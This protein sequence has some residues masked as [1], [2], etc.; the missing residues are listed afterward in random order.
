VGAFQRAT[1]FLR[2]SPGDPTAYRDIAL[3]VVLVAAVFGFGASDTGKKF[4][5]PKLYWT[6]Q[7]Q[8]VDQHITLDDERHI[9]QA[10]AFSDELDM[11]YGTFEQARLEGLRLYPGSPTQAREHARVAAQKVELV[12]DKMEAFMRQDSERHAKLL[13]TCE[14]IVQQLQKY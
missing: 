9:K 7:K 4:F 14:F 11:A 5:R 3:V 8:L 13:A 2:P 6:E 12:T 10:V 1:H